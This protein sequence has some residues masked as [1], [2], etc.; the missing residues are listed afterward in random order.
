MS[1]SPGTV[2]SGVTVGAGV[3]VGGAAGDGKALGFFV[4]PLIAVDIDT[5][6]LLGLCWSKIWT[7]SDRPL[8]DR[9]KRD[10]ADKE[11]YR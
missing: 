10:F 9:R 8:R 2:G 3:A 1:S 11:S 5:E 6:A 4:H 7:R